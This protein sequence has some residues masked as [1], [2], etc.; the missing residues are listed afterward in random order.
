MC[1]LPPPPFASKAFWHLR[2]PNPF[3]WDNTYC[4]RKLL[5]FVAPQSISQFQQQQLLQEMFSHQQLLPQIFSHHLSLLCYASFSLRQYPLQGETHKI[6]CTTIPFLNFNNKRKKEKKNNC[7]GKKYFLTIFLS[8][9]KCTTT[10]N[11]Q[12]LSS[13]LI[14][15]HLNMLC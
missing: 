7:C 14:N 12:I 5:R 15:F 8:S 6:S 4:K 1:L 13:T 3:L 2:I 10:K 9:M 11:I